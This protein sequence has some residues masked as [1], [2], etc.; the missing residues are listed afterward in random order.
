MRLEDRERERA[1]HQ[2][3][4][5]GRAG[6]S[7]CV[8]AEDLEGLR[9]AADVGGN[10]VE[11]NVSDDAPVEV[12]G[13]LANEEHEEHGV[14]VLVS[15]DHPDG[16]EDSAE[17]DPNP[18]DERVSPGKPGLQAGGEDHTQ[19]YSNY[20]RHHG[21][22]TEDQFNILLG[23]LSVLRLLGQQAFPDEVRAKPGEGSQAECD[24]GEAKGG[25]DEALVLGQTDDVLLK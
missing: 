17:D 13:D 5:I 23:N 9:C 21:H 24:A 15:Q 2:S 12:E 6:V 22:H 20:A 7:K 4:Q 19:R 18:T 8:T 16:E 14:D 10:D 25:E 11:E 3:D 1:T